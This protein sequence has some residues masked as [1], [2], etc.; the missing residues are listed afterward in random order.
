MDQK[1][2]GRES[3]KGRVVLGHGAA[4]LQRPFQRDR[5]LSA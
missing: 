2:V 4:N 3:R 5:W 1:K